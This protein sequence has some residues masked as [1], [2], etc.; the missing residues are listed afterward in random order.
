MAVYKSKYTGEQIDS[1]V[2]KIST[3][4]TSP[5]YQNIVYEYE[6]SGSSVKHYV[7]F[8]YYSKTPL[9]VNNK[10]G[11][12]DNPPEKISNETLGK[13]LQ[14]VFEYDGINSIW[15]P[16][17]V[18][19][20]VYDDDDNG[21][22]YTT[23]PAYGRVYFTSGDIRFQYVCRMPSKTNKYGNQSINFYESIYGGTPLGSYYATTQQIY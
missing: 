19:G 5:L 1:A 20:I 13:H 14:T 18:F 8:I 6:I 11:V 16:V 17:Q 10:W 7:G 4:Q 2:E 21:G 15:A 12:G 9:V 22:Y 3:A 23:T